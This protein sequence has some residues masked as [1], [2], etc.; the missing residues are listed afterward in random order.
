MDLAG[1][2]PGLA[3]ENCER[4][5]KTPTDP[6]PEAQ[7]LCKGTNKTNK[8]IFSETMGGGH[9][10][11]ASEKCEETTET[12]RFNAKSTETV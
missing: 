10:G 5:P 4:K 11:L 1:G 2:L 9:P 7:K 12:N 3:S 8:T 6:M